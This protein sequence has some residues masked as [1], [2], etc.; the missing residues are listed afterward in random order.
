M[1]ESVGARIDKLRTVAL[2]FSD[3]HGDEDTAVLLDGAANS[4]EV[5]MAELRTLRADK[6]KIRAAAEAYEK[7]PLDIRDD[8]KSWQLIWLLLETAK[9]NHG[10]E[11]E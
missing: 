3:V 2:H 4:I 1:G 5:L 9:G 11:A 6:E 8:P 7:N 10:E